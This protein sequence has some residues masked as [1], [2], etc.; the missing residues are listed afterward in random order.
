M[1]CFVLSNCWESCMKLF[2]D[3]YTS[4][5]SNSVLLGVFK[6]IYNGI[7]WGNRCGDW[8]QSFGIT[9]AFTSSFLNMSERTSSGSMLKI[10]FSKAGCKRKK[11][12]SKS[13][14][15]QHLCRWETS[16]PWVKTLIVKL[17]RPSLR[18]I[19]SFRPWRFEWLR[20]PRP[21]EPQYT[22]DSF[23]QRSHCQPNHVW[24]AKKSLNILVQN[25]EKNNSEQASTHIQTYIVKKNAYQRMLVDCLDWY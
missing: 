6:N 10:A 25:C 21:Q 1:C 23:A 3:N 14:D 12:V 5:D 7:I 13:T 22:H 19:Y 18:T 17:E 15:M 11:W 4:E 2:K 9:C 20:D 8:W 24:V 16:D